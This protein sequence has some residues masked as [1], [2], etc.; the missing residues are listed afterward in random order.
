MLSF[1]PSTLLLNLQS[2]WNA[3]IVNLH[4]SGSSSSV[5]SCIFSSSKASQYSSNSSRKRSSRSRKNSWNGSKSTTVLAVDDSISLFSSFVSIGAR[6][7]NEIAADASIGLIS[8]LVICSNCFP[9][10][11]MIFSKW[12]NV[13]SCASFDCI[14]L[15]S[16]CNTQYRIAPGVSKLEP[17][18]GHNCSGRTK[19]AA[20]RCVASIAASASFGNSLR[21]SCDDV[22]ALMS[23]DVDASIERSHLCGFS[24]PSLVSSCIRTASHPDKISSSFSLKPVGKQCH[25]DETSAGFGSATSSVWARICN[26]RDGCSREDARNASTIKTLQAVMSKRSWE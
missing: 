20:H 23:F 24:V 21:S 11:L 25:R 9:A 3:A 7:T 13:T 15:V 22:S 4:P 16:T 19:F 18:H 12:L 14:F 1:L 5:T 17:A 26:E 8:S 10:S 6:M 2:G